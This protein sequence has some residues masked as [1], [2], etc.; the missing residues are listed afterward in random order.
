ML[1]NRHFRFRLSLGSCRPGLLYWYIVRLAT[2][3]VGMMTSSAEECWRLSR[4]CGRWAAETR[5]GATRLAFRQMA[6]AWGRLAFGEEF[7]S[8][9]KEHMDPPSTE[10]SAAIAED[11]SWSAPAIPS[12]EM[13]DP[14]VDSKTGSIK[15]I[16]LQTARQ[17]LQEIERAQMFQVAE[18]D[19]LRGQPEL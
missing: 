5:D 19:L 10:D 4:D 15:S 16:T 2:K 17:L 14:Q 12:S 9:A 3:R 8:A 11:Q 1:R 6:T 18:R 7:T 13:I